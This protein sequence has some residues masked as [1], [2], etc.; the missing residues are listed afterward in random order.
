MAKEAKIIEF[1]LKEDGRLGEQP[2]S[3]TGTVK[4]FEEYR[5]EGWAPVHFFEAVYGERGQQIN[6]VRVLMERESLQFTFL[7]RFTVSVVN[8]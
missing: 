4:F 2:E 8:R 6:R 7:K 3:D 5:A 1:D